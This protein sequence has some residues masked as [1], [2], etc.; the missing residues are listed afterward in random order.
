ML[1]VADPVRQVTTCAAGRQWRAC[2]R[3]E[4]ARSR[5]A[6]DLAIEL[7]RQQGARRR[8][9]AR[10]ELDRPDLLAGAGGAQ[11]VDHARMLWF[12]GCFWIDA[13]LAL[14]PAAR[15]DGEAGG[16]GGGPCS[17]AA[18]ESWACPPYTAVWD[19]SASSARSVHL[20]SRLAASPR[21]PGFLQRRLLMVA[22]ESPESAALAA[23]TEGTGI[24]Q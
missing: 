5:A 11:I 17:T 24:G 16:P 21:D 12:T 15:P 1:P 14:L 19:G 3:V 23:P 13:A 8:R 10:E 6:L 9:S 2:S 22:A 4:T 7:Y 18:S 20:R